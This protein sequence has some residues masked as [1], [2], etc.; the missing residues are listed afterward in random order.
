MTP[1]ETPELQKCLKTVSA[2]KLKNTPSLQLKDFGSIEL[3]ARKILSSKK[4]PQRWENFLS[5]SSQ[6]EAG[7]R[8]RNPN[9]H[10]QM[11]SSVNNFRKKLGLKKGTRLSPHYRKM[12]PIPR[13]P[14]YPMPIPL[15]DLQQRHR[16][17]RIPQYPTTASTSTRICGGYRE[18]T[19]TALSVDGGKARLRTDRRTSQ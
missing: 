16:N 1:E 13:V 18:K 4:Q 19:V 12:L 5:S 6:T 17:I 7:S 8:Q 2:I 9:L 10:G 15:L 14:T 3:A 11:A